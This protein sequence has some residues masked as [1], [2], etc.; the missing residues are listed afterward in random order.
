[1]KIG[2]LVEGSVRARRS[3]GRSP[4][5]AGSE[6]EFLPPPPLQV[7]T[8]ASIEVEVPGFEKA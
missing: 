8:A 2:E 5:A 4:A 6:A 7:T 3:C 1:M